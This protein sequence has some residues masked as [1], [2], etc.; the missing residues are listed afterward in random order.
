[1]IKTLPILLLLS[2]TPYDMATKKYRPDS[3]SQ[4]IAKGGS[5]NPQKI[6]SAAGALRGEFD[7]QNANQNLID[8]QD[9]INEDRQLK[10]LEQ[11]K[12]NAQAFGKDMV[13]LAELSGTLTSALVGVQE[14]RNQEARERGLSKAYADGVPEAEQAEFDTNYENLKQL[15][16]QGRAAAADAEAKGVPPERVRQIR[17]LSGWEAVGY[18]EGQARLGGFLYGDYYREA[19][20]TMKFMVNGEEITYAQAKTLPQRQEVEAQIRQSYLAKYKDMKPALLNKFMFPQMKKYEAAAAQEWQN[21]QDTLLQNERK[22]EAKQFIFSGIQ[23]NNAGEI[24]YQA[25]DLFKDDLGGDAAARQFIA[26]HLE[27]LADKGLLTPD[28][29]RAILEHPF[30]DR[31]GA[32]TTI[33]KKFSE[34][35]DL[36]EKALNY[37]Y[38]KSQEAEKIRKI[39]QRDYT[40]KLKQQEQAM[41]QEQPPRRFTEDHKKQMLDDWEKDFGGDPP[42]YLKNLVTREDEDDESKREQL[43]QLLY[44]KKYI[45]EGD[46]I[47][48]SLKI[49]QEYADKVVD[50]SSVASLPKAFTSEATKTI[51]AHIKSAGVLSGAGA[52]TAH[53]NAPYAEARAMEMYRSRVAE[54]LKTMTANEAHLKA[55]DDVKV[56]LTPVG[57]DGKPLAGAGLDETPIVRMKGTPLVSEEQEA[58]RSA[59]LKYVGNNPDKLATT[60]IPNTKTELEALEQLAKTGKGN[61]PQLY[62]IIARNTNGMY[63][64]WDIAEAQLQASGKGLTLNRPPVEQ[65]VQKLNPNL[66]TMLNLKPSNARTYAVM[67]GG[68]QVAGPAVSSGL[69]GNW[70]TFLDLVASV[71][72]EAHGGYDAYNLGGSAG[73]HVAHG[74]GNSNDGRFGKPL[75]Q[76]TV[77]EVLDLGKAPTGRHIH[78]AGRYQFIP[79]TLAETVIEAGIDPRTTLF[80]E[81]TQDRLAVAR[82]RWRIRTDRGM[83]GLRREWIGLT[84]VRDAVLRPAMNAIVD[85]KSPY[86][87]PDVL[88]PAVR[89]KV[90]K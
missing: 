35:A 52:M 58:K 46:L 4:V 20:R 78:A 71:E 8:E 10:N 63:S 11:R 57:D 14:A 49:R 6:G 87:Q 50:T 56:A 53:P 13:A 66:Q 54:H 5:F 27:D 7:R 39:N 64:G 40:E 61:I 81:A 48:A 3:P 84:N 45:T 89:R 16:A 29:A 77:Q 82:A 70:K 18:A 73:G 1:M 72:S 76:M 90:Y 67:T 15:D 80:D 25:L 9:R 26:T 42:E 21:E 34:F 32:L 86:N 12:L 22:D 65:E 59:A 31:S 37:D 17:K 55:L 41:L 60:V 62:H 43:D 33:G 74:S 47:G 83:A 2:T 38:T 44:S 68:Y 51:Q 85:T 28:Q 23:T 30:I 79:T 69:Q 24:V 36:D 19:K 75:T 88:S